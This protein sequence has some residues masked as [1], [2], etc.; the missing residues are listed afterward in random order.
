MKRNKTMHSLGRGLL[1]FFM[2]AALILFSLTCIFPIIWMGYSSLKEK[3]AFNADIIGLP[4]KPSLVNYSRILSNPD[5]HLSES[6]LNSVRTTAL[7]IVF[8]IVFSFVVGYILARVSFRLNRVLYA[9]FLL[10]MLIPVHSLLVPIYVVFRNCG[11]SNQWFTLIFPYVSFGLP[12]GIFLMEGYVKGIPVSLEEAAAID[13]CSVYRTFVSI[14]VPMVKPA[15]VTQGMLMYINNWNEYALA[16]ILAMGKEM[17]P[18]PLALDLF[19]GQFDLTNWG[20][21]GAAVAITSLPV[22]VVFML[23]NKQIE[24]A[25]TGSSGLK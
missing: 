12:M 10:G 25:M 2:N 24:Q 21:V 17:R 3:R 14:M 20:E 5:Y 18:I 15:L 4:K 16:S 6:M 13:G 8:I 1:S 22:I 11:I 7:S 23:C 19:F 9:M